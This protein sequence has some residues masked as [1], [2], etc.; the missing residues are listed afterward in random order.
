[1]PNESAQ[2]ERRYF[3]GGSDSRII[4]A[5]L[6]RLRRHM[7]AEVKRKD[8]PLGEATKVPFQGHHPRRMAGAGVGH[9]LEAV[10]SAA[11][12]N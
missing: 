9:D 4:E 10:V 1:M 6:L 8:L 7:P 11:V 5:A 3:I 12:G 2:F